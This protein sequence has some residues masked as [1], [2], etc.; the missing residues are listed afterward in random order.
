MK[1]L[2]LILLTL[3]CLVGCKKDVNQSFVINGKINGDIPKYIYLKYGNIKDSSLIENN[4]FKFYGVIKNP[5][6]ADF[7]IHPISSINK[8]F[9]IENSSFDIEITSEKKKY[10]DIE[11]NFIN[12]DT[13][14][15]NNTSKIQYDFENFIK[16]FKNSSDWESKLSNKLN[17]LILKN[18]ENQYSGDI[19]SEI[20]EQSILPINEIE[21]L[22]KKLDLEKQSKNSIWRIKKIL[23][24][25]EKINVGQNISDFELPNNKGFLI[26]TNSFRGKYLLIDFWA[27]WCIP[28]RKQNIELL[29]VY[30]NHKNKDLEI[31]GVSIDNNKANWLKAIDKDSI[32]WQ[33]VIEIN[34]FES[35][36][37]QKYNVI[38]AI[39]HNYLIDPNGKI[40]KENI[41]INELEK[42][43]NE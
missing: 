43:L 17:E 14:F 9:Y 18:P 12:I 24:P 11:L 32:I 40:I 33:N 1:N 27:S 13:I 21:S 30:K 31:L 19:L 10:K 28:C 6:K 39:P 8:S 4:E 26:N 16:E 3:L 20:T 37:L 35:D 42:L 7:V 29:K 34:G 15:N 22:F 41:S 25:I 38:S 23:Y 2:I 36:I 5:T